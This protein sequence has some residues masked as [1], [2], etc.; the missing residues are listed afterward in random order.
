[1]YNQYDQ[2]ETICNVLKSRP[3][4]VADIRGSIAYPAINGIANF[5]QVREGVLIVIS[6]F[7]L[8]DI[9]QPCKDGIFAMHIHSGGSC[10]G[11]AED[12]FADVKMH[13]NPDNCPH[14]QHAGDLPPIFSNEGFA[15]SSFLT[16]RFSVEEIIGKTII[17][18][19]LPD[20]FTTQPSGNSGQKIA[21]GIISKI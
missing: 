4:A 19:D 2:L 13:Y 10:T 20:D 7:G 12:P 6:I 21:C 18:H 3:D 17:V 11:N 8:P 9:S 15:W 14:P 1:M 5:Y 16:N